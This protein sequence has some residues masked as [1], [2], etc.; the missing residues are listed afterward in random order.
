MQESSWTALFFAAKNGHVDVFQSLLGY[1]AKTEIKVSSTNI[2]ISCIVL[3]YSICLTLKDKD[4]TS[5]SVINVASHL[6]QMQILSAMGT[7]VDYV[8]IHKDSETA[9]NIIHEEVILF[10]RF[11]LF[12][13]KVDKK[14]R[15]MDSIIL[16]LEKRLAIG[17]LKM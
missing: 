14:V 1:G 6:K 17:G 12:W 15:L 9:V 5:L 13:Q 10:L 8:P 11:V 16:A 7:S 4:G 3:R 2:A